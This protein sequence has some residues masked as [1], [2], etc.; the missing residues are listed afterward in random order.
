MNKNNRMFRTDH[1]YEIEYN[2]DC[3]VSRDLKTVE[4]IFNKDRFLKS[5]KI[6]LESYYESLNI[7]KQNNMKNIVIRPI[8]GSIDAIKRCDIH[9]TVMYQSR[10]HID[11]VKIFKVKNPVIKGIDTITTSIGTIY[12]SGALVINVPCDTLAPKIDVLHAILDLV[13]LY[14]E[15]NNINY[16]EISNESYRGWYETK[17]KPLRKVNETEYYI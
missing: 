5:I 1:Q 12:G 2:R 6:F 15:K 4:I 16:Y 8:T 9:P 13:F 3:A 7:S 11:Y 17:D 14:F 10:I